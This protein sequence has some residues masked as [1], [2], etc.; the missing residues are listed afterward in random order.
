M[1]AQPQKH[2]A[3]HANDAH[4]K[5][6]HGA[7]AHGSQAHGAEGH[8]HDA[9]GAEAG[10]HGGGR[11]KRHEEDHKTHGEGWLMSFCDLLTDRKSVV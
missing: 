9:H 8:G 1:S 4:G 7:D 3:S 2:D 6:T 11:K 10:A 5:D